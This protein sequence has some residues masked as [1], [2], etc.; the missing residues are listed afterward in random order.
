MNKQKNLLLVASALASALAL[1][2]G[3]ALAA[4]QAPAQEETQ[5]QQQEQIYGS[6][7]M[8]QQERTEYR[9]KMR[10]AT[11]AAERE[12]IR[13]E[14]H[15]QM[16]ERAKERG[17][18]LP[19]EPP[20]RGGGM[21]PGG[22]GMGP[23]SNGMMGP[24]GGGMMGPG[25]MRGQP[26]A[27]GEAQTQ[28]QGKIYGSQLMTQQER[29]EYRAKMRGATTAAEREQIRNEHHQQMQE[30]AKE[31]GMTLPTEPP[32]RG[33]GMGPG[34]GGMG[35]GGG[36]MGPSGGAMGPGGGGMGPGG[37]RGQPPAQQD[38]QTQQQ[39]QIYGSQLMTQQERTEYRAKMRDATTAAEREQIRNEHHEQMQERAKERGVTLPAE[40][41]ARGGGMGPGGG[42]T[43]SGGVGG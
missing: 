26:P 27:Q 15:Q 35:P 32:A 3:V 41:P 6:Q 12:Q 42:G 43:G 34:G 9:A 14:H 39:E 33:G 5:T 13:S 29:T 21:G 31:R 36:G 19:A 22:G 10:G 24:G 8:T 18:T 40:P 38:A 17:V 37:M 30:R 28:Q 11:T 25:G 4:G 7:L 2:A 23:G 20:A 1:S 16:Q